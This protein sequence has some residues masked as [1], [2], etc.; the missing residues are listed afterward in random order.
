M[1]N[2][3]RT[4]NPLFGNIAEELRRQTSPRSRHKRLHSDFQE[5]PIE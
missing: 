5:L 2:T 1:T 4:N 3:R